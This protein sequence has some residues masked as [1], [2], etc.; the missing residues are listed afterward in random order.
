MVIAVLS[1]IHFFSHHLAKSLPVQLRLI[2]SPRPYMHD[3][4][5]S[6]CLEILEIRGDGNE[7]IDLFRCYLQIN[8]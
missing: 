1:F 8:I 6:N 7:F 4:C 3:T 2:Y 5:I